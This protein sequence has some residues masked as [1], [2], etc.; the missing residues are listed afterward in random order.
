MRILHLLNHVRK[1]GNG[2]VNVTVDLACLQSKAGCGVFVASAGGE[3]E[4]LLKQFGVHHVHLNQRRR[5]IQL[6]STSFRYRKLVRDIEPDIVHAHMMTGAVLARILQGQ[7]PYSIVS[8]VHNEFQHGAIVMGVADRVIAVSQAVAVSMAR[9][10]I[11]TN[12]LRVVRNGTLG[13]PR[14]G[15]ADAPVRLRRPAIVTLAGMYHRKGISELIQAF[16][17]VSPVFTDAH[18][19]LIGNGPD[20]G[21]FEQQARRTSVNERIHFEGFQPDPQRYLLAADIFVLASR[22]DPFP[23]V[24]SEA[25]EAGCAIVASRVDGI[26]E[27]LDGGRAGWLVPPADSRALAR[28]IAELLQ[29]P[30]LLSTWKYKARQNTD[31]LSAARVNQETLEVYRDI[32]RSGQRV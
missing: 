31:W 2:I 12:K 11:P 4:S 17:Q 9:R 1:I 5:P 15:A 29:Q 3:F 6:L 25:R 32:R 13:S 8:T 7:S 20:R 27:A 10:G 18:L 16:A 19:Y 22:Q 30:P 14:V 24:L 28:A 26:P 23:L 21:E